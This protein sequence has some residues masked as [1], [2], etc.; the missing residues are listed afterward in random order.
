[1]SN[2]K[3][4]L[5]AV[6]SFMANLTK[7]PEVLAADEMPEQEPAQEAVPAAN[8]APAQEAPIQE[9]YVTL[10]QFNELQ[11]STQKFMETV[12]EML[13][14]AMEMWN[15]TEKNTVPQ[16]MS[17]QQPEVKEEAVELAAEPFVH[18]PETVVSSKPAFG[19]VSMNKPMTTS[20]VVNAM[21]FGEGNDLSIFESK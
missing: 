21:L 9:A 19:K 7:E 11:E 4:K 15:Q 13:S 10:A 16:E 8:A 2:Y 18:D 3:E 17:E 12:T 5:E 1:M 20:Q 6:K 14:S